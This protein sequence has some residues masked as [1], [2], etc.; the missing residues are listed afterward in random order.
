MFSPTEQDPPFTEH[1]ET[2]LHSTTQLEFIQSTSN[3]HV[4]PENQSYIHDFGYEADFQA[5]NLDQGFSNN[6]TYNIFTDVETPTLQ[7]WVHNFS[8]KIL[9]DC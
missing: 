9:S 7:A 5:P 2:S 1:D 8:P 3:L 4:N 6:K